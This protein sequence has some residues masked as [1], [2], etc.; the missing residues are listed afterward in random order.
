MVFKSTMLKYGLLGG[1]VEN[2]DTAMKLFNSG[3]N[4][5]WGF[6][7]L[8]VLYDFAFSKHVASELNIEFTKHQTFQP[9]IDDYETGVEFKFSH[10]KYWY[11]VRVTKSVLEQYLSY[12]E[13]PYRHSIVNIKVNDDKKLSAKI[14]QYIGVDH[15]NIL[16]INYL[17]TPLNW[18]RPL[19]NLHVKRNDLNN[20]RIRRLLE[21]HKKQDLWDD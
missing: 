19:Q 1:E 21:E 15:W 16:D 13:E 20:E 3:K 14:Q 17:K 11:E 8:W 5:L 6:Y 12:D 18:Y 2:P 10:D 9:K 7:G 4:D